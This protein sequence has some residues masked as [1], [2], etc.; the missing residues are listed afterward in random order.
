[1]CLSSTLGGDFYWGTVRAWCGTHVYWP[2]G[3]PCEC[4]VGAFCLKQVLLRQILETN[5]LSVASSTFPLGI[6]HGATYTLWIGSTVTC[7]APRVR[8]VTRHALCLGVSP[9]L[10]DGNLSLTRSE[11]C[12]GMPV[13]LLVP[14]TLWWIFPACLSPFIWFSLLSGA[15]FPPTFLSDSVS[16]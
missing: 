5:S 2:Q 1:M 9:A 6:F 15:P 4:T 10:A 13:F 3:T 8:L 11:P 14:A 7:G 16:V 12:E